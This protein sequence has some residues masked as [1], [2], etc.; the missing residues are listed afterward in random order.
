VLETETT[1]ETAPGKKSKQARRSFDINY[2]VP[3]RNQHPDLSSTLSTKPDLINNQLFDCPILEATLVEDEEVAEEEKQ[4]SVHI[5]IEPTGPVYDAVLV[6]D[7]E[8]DTTNDGRRDKRHNGDKALLY[9]CILFAGVVLMVLIIGVVTAAV[10]GKNN[11]DVTS[12][13][14]PPST[15]EDDVLWDELVYLT[16]ATTSTE[17]FPHKPPSTVENALVSDS[18]SSTTSTFTIQGYRWIDTNNDGIY[19]FSE[20]PAPVGF[21]NLRNCSDDQRVKTA[22]SSS[23]GLYQFLGIPEGE[24]Y[25]QF[26]RPSHECTSSMKL[27]D[28]CL[29]AMFIRVLFIHCKR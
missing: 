9:S 12:Q 4:D 8:E 2:G 14:K 17:N 29:G 24:Y 27:Y 3:A 11:R 13:Q 1:A 22:Q 15:V 18:T 21:I 16:T 25:I 26:F 6:P 7:E 19:Q 23:N 5:H 28:V 20:S 10:I